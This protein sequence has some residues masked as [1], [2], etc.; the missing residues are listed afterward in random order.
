MKIFKPEDFNHEQFTSDTANRIFELWLEKQQ[1]V[2]SHY[3]RGFDSNKWRIFDLG[4]DHEKAT[5]KARLVCIEPIAK[6]CEHK[7]VS[8]QFKEWKYTETICHG[9][10][11]KLVPASWRVE[12]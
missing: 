1:V 8:H 10:G 2:Y 9:C 7:D 5:H 11:K 4:R 12:E 3:G 6:E